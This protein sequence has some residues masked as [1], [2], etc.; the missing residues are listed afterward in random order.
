ML[1]G[2][3]VPRLNHRLAKKLATSPPGAQSR[4]MPP[5]GAISRRALLC[6]S[7]GLGLCLAAFPAFAWTSDLNGA[8]RI[9][10]VYST[11]F[12]FDA[13][14][15][16]RVSIGLAH[17]LDEVRLSAPA[18]LRAL[19]SGEGG[20]TIV[21]GTRW[22]IRITASQPSSQHFRVVLEELPATAQADIDAA[23]RRW[24]I[25]GLVPRL[26]EV[27]TVFGVGGHVLDTRR[28]LV[29]T[30]EWSDEHEATRQATKLTARYRALGKL[31]P[32]VQ[33]RS[34]GMLIARD[35]DRGV[36][37]RAE[38]VLWFASEKDEPI[39]VLDLP[40][41]ASTRET[42]SY[43]GLIYVAV[44]RNGRLAVVNLVSETDALCGLV[45]AEM[46]PSAPMDALAAQAVAARGQLLA[47]IGTRH[48]D[49]PFLVCADQHCQ[50]Y[51]GV[52]REHPR[53][54]RAVRDTAGIVLFR[55]NG[56]Q[57]VDTVYSANCGGHSEHNEHVWPS[58]PDAQLR[59]KPDVIGESKFSRGIDAD[60][61]REWLETA[62]PSHSKPEHSALMSSYRWQAS[63]DPMSLPGR[64]G[65]P[66]SIG[67]V[68]SLR[69]IA[70][71]K[72]GR[73]TRL[74]VGGTNGDVELVGELVIRR[75]LG[76][77]KSS[78]FLVRPDRDAHGRFQL[79]GGGH[80]HGVGLCQ[81]GAIGM[82]NA[83]RSYQHILAHYYT[84]SRVARLW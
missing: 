19:P 10:L 44:D 50:V 80:G 17:G 58:P 5:Q 35:L 74:V 34:H 60:N 39:A 61:L 83:G 66:R 24:K 59:G 76:D 47:N 41:G 84:G 53:T 73:A 11:Q 9:D 40:K 57:L 71:G 68:R 82:A 81:H 23:V 1:S 78:M 13:S 38:D 26:D 3:R 20:T 49:D 69:V 12:R 77:L 48:L 31:H 43:R 25:R 51:A 52:A 55:P 64:P 42:R 29:T 36:E 45:P 15:E 33:R 72:S 32:T 2:T 79:I 65:V 28:I 7:P 54:T 63:L 30:G 46:F 4:S 27:G 16:P 37:V 22:A 56:T 62:P 18:G 21:G 70:R 14:G 67:A 8:D 6:S 75:A